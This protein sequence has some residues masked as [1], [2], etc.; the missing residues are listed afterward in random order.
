MARIPTLFWTP[1]A[2]HCID[3]MLEEIGKIPEF[4]SYIT[5][6]KRVTTFIY[7]HGK[8]LDAMRDKT[9]GYDLVRPAATRFATSFLTL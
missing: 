9:G 1:C 7:R 3:L 5:K 6:A 4:N 8:L 2:A